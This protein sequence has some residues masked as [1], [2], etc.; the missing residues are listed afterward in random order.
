MYLHFYIFDHI[1]ESFCISTGKTERKEATV[2]D[3][4]AESPPLRSSRRP[5]PFP[6]PVHVSDNFPCN[7]DVTLSEQKGLVSCSREGKS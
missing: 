1:F 6:S 3:F 5:P 2:L 4:I 7:E